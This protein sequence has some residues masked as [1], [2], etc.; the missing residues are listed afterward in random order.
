[1]VA[2]APEVAVGKFV[3]VIFVSEGT[4][5]VGWATIAGGGVVE[6]KA[7]SNGVDEETVLG[8]EGPG[9]GAAGMVAADSNRF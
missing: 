1:M 8:V 4:E 5:P 9:A 7:F 2:G 6:A 3:S